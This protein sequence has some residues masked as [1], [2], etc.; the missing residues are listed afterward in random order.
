MDMQF[1][2]KGIFIVV[3]VSGVPLLISAGISLIVAFLQTIT[4]IQEQS[5]SYIIKCLVVGVSFYFG[6]EYLQTLIFDF[7]NSAFEEVIKYGSL[8]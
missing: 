4:Q 3:I 6:Y 1:L 5:L 7:F 8:S 2:Y